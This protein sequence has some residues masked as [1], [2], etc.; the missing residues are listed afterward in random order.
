MI[1]TAIFSFALAV[2][3]SVILYAIGMLLHEHLDGTARVLLNRS[4]AN[5]DSE[6]EQ[7]VI[8]IIQFIGKCTK[9]IAVGTVLAT[10]IA[11]IAFGSLPGGNFHL[12]FG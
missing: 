5:M 8:G 4:L 12:N 2:V 10:L 7:R 9:V 3:Q 1:F 11:L 6:E